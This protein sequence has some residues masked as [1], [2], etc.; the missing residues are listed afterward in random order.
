MAVRRG[1]AGRDVQHYGAVI[2]LKQVCRYGG[3]GEVS[4]LHALPNLPTENALNDALG[5]LVEKTL[6]GQE[7]VEG[8]A[9]RAALGL[10]YS[11]PPNGR[12]GPFSGT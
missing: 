7:F 11:P 10:G 4:G 5:G 12:R 6:L 3:L 1:G 2:R 8:G 9:G